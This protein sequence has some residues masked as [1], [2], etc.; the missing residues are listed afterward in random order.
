MKDNVGI[1]DWAH[2]GE[3]PAADV[4]FRVTSAD[5]QMVALH[6]GVGMTTLPCFVGDV[7]PLL[8]RVPGTELRHHGTLWLLTQGETRRTKRVRLLTEFIAER[9]TSFT[10]LLA[11][12]T[13]P[14]D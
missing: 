8:A 6:A 14:S 11:G 12:Q 5:A 10:P 1:G 7:D 9:L 13:T 4:S 3:V 2:T